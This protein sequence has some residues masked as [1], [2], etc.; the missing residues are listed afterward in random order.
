MEG[1][2]SDLSECGFA[3]PQEYAE[4]VDRTFRYSD[5]NNS[6]RVVQEIMKLSE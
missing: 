4:R 5:V 1:Y 2:L 3:M 6:E